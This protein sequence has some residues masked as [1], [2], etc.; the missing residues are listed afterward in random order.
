M[1]PNLVNISSHRKRMLKL[2][3]WLLM[4]DVFATL[5][6]SMSSRV[7][8]NQQSRN[9]SFML[10]RVLPIKFLC[11]KDTCCLLLLFSELLKYNVFKSFIKII[12]VSM[13]FLFV[14]LFQMQQYYVKSFINS[15][16]NQVQEKVR[17][18]SVNTKLLMD[19][20]DFTSKICQKIEICI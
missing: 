3:L 8:S 14:K 18:F 16:N 20:A 15:F 19:F 10:I 12:R 4:S 1:A 13:I 6:L 2:M 7:E 11:V 9:G 5:I 17:I